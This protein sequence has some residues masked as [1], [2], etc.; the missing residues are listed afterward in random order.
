MSES[1]DP[2][3]T[4]NIYVLD[5]TNNGENG[6]PDH[7][8]SSGCCF[9]DYPQIG[10]DANGFYVTT[11]ELDNLG[12]GELRGAQLYAFSKADLAAGDPTPASAYL[13]NVATTTLGDVAYTTQ[14]V[15]ATPAEWDRSGDGTMYFGMSASP[16]TSSGASNRMVRRI[17]GPRRLL[18]AAVGRLR[19]RHGLARRTRVARR[20]V[21][22]ADLHV[23]RVVRRHDV[24]VHP[25]VPG[26][27]LDQDRR[28]E[29]LSRDAP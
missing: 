24:R 6:T 8:C 12:A 27:L 11:N 20:A 16:Y 17:H 7:Q 2:L 3:G 4:W 13:E 15:N 14:P 18:P 9:G 23:R 5:N 10:I 29:R 25:H 26:E 21:D 19:R 22:R 28:G 1:A